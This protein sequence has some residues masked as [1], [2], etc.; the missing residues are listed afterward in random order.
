[1][2]FFYF[3]VFYAGFTAHFRNCFTYVNQIGKADVSSWEQLPD[4][5]SAELGVLLLFSLL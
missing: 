4:I 2:C 1:M 5:S 3:F